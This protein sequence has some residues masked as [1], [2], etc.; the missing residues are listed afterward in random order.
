MAKKPTTR[1]RDFNTLADAIVKTATGE[2]ESLPGKDSAAVESGRRGGLKGG[3][4]RAEKLTPEERRAIASRAAKA[5][6][7]RGED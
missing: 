3:A 6:W 7:G 4:A 2:T 5:R 1:S